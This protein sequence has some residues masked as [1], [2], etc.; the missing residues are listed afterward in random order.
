MVI[1]MTT[2]TNGRQPRNGFLTNVF[3]GVSLMMHLCRLGAAVDALSA[4]A[5]EDNMPLPLPVIR[6]EINV[7]V[8]R[9]TILTS[10]T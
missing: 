8:I 10:L 2:F 9:L 1:F 3:A 7:V 4:I 6:L 5:L